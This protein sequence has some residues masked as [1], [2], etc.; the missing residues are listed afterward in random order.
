LAHQ[1]RPHHF[2]GV[3]SESNIFVVQ[4]DDDFRK[5]FFLD[6]AQLRLV[7]QRARELRVAQALEELEAMLGPFIRR[8]D[9]QLLNERLKITT[10]NLQLSSRAGRQRRR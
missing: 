7:R 4:P 6:L 1:D 9:K 3:K 5:I 8:R 10:L 2:V